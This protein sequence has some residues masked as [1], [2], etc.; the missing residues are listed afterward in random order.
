MTKIE[1]IARYRVHAVILG[2]DTFKAISAPKEL[3]THRAEALLNFPG[4]VDKLLGEIYEELTTKQA[5]MNGAPKP[6]VRV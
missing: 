3:A 4:Q 5:S 2:M 1:F 6:G